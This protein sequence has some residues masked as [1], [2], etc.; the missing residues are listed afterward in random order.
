MSGRQFTWANSL[1]SPTYEKL[2]RVLMTTEWEFKFP[3]VS[4]RALDRGVS[5]HTPLLLDTGDAAFKGNNR[6]F[7]L[8]PSW[9]T[10]DDFYARLVEIWNKPV[11]GMNSVQRWNRKMSALRRHLRGWAANNVGIYKQQKGNLIST[12]DKL[13]VEAES[14]DLTTQERHDLSQARDQLARLLR[15]EELKYYQR[16]KV[17]DVLLRDNN[18]KYFQMVA[19]GKHRKKRIFSLNHE[20]GKIEG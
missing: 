3:L 5:D 8:E 16:A 11:R 2:D 4:V 20:N 12:I 7:K 10:R 17:M 1:P 15:E 14:H 19:N 18:T 9:F 6:Q 13:D